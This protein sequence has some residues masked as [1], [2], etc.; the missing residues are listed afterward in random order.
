MINPKFV[1]NASFT[2]LMEG[3]YS[4]IQ[5]DYTTSATHFELDWMRNDV[6]AAAEFHRVDCIK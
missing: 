4:A 5:F 6:A 1:T 3:M 2:D